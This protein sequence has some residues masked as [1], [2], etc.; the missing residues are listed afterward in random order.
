VTT[1]APDAATRPR[2][3]N[4]RYLL[5]REGILGPLLLLPSVAYLLALV[6]F[7]LVMAILYAFTDIT[8]GNPA[9]HFVGLDTFKAALS[10][11]VTRTSLRNTVVFTLISQ[12]LVVVL[13][14]VLAFALRVN[15]RGK[16]IARFLILL[17]WTTPSRSGPSPGCGCSTRSSARSTGCSPTWASPARAATCSGWAARTWPWAR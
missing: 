4:R 15:F 3:R 12:I 5:E 11:P 1:A 6:A 17:P 2:E 7:P 8:T 13:S 10:D 9:L 16:W 14:V